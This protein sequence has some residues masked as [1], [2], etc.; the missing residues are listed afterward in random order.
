MNQDN[1]TPSD[2]KF[3]A[4]Y[5]RSKKE[6]DSALG[7]MDQRAAVLRYTEGRG[8]VIAEHTELESG[9]AR[10][11]E[12]R[13]VI[14]RA[15]AQATAND[16]ILVIARLDRLA[17]DTEFTSMLYNTGVR[18]ICCDNPEA[19]ELTIKMLS[20]VAENEA[21]NISRNTKAGLAQA[22]LLGTPLGC[23]AHTTPGCKLT[24]DA[25][26]KA[27]ESKRLNARINPNNRK[28]AAYAFSLFQ[29]GKS[30]VEIVSIMKSHGFTSP[31]GG[32][33]FPM[34]VSRWIRIMQT[35]SVEPALHI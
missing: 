22:K 29:A 8:I 4:Y 3:I 5:R 2:K 17:R 26:K 14:K 24:D 11:R 23:T 31:S 13:H 20:V 25:R 12:K 6:H 1:N 18:F 34:T 30:L 28:G 16:A 33:I 21:K 15:I 19:N 35:G 9:T 27:L 32:N 7:L 10:R